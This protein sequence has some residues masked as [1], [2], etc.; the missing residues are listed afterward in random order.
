MKRTII[1][2]PSLAPGALDEL[3]QWL[4]ITT[5]RDDAALTALLRSALDACEGFT[6]Q[7]PL[8]ALCEEVLPA[9][10]G[11][12]DLSTTPVQSITSLATLGAD[13]TRTDLDPGD[14]LFDI[15]AGGCGRI[16]LLVSPE[17]SRIAALFSAGL[18]PDWGSLSEGLRHGV[19]RLAAHQY[20]ERNDGGGDR[21]PPAAIAALWQPWRR[22]RVA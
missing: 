3:K 14:Y 12:H 18:A 10:R 11:W 4:A 17:Q 21:S 2:P 13:G 22:I 9:T 16:N 5:T 6:R 8:E 19:I 1:S 15:T 7:M 20:R